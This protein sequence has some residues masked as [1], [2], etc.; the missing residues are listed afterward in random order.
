MQNIWATFVTKFATKKFNKITQSG[1]TSSGSV[2]RAVASIPE[3]RSS[4]PVIGNFYTNH[5]CGLLKRLE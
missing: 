1:H 2:G 5:F 3:I 4:N